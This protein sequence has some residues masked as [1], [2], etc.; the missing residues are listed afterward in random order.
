MKTQ[1]DILM[2]SPEFRKLLAIEALVADASELIAR[3]MAEQNLSKADLA[4]KLGKS[5]AWMTQLLNGKANMTIRTLAEVVYELD[6]EVKLNTQAPSW[7][8]TGKPA[9][10]GWQP[11]FKMDDYLVQP[12][13]TPESLFRLK[14]NQMTP[15][16]EELATVGPGEPSQSE[17]AA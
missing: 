2:E 14:T 8:I 11:V 3:L 12:T 9:S 5:R 15:V 7:K 17:Y 6:A 1:H 10:R 13:A 16:G 4:R